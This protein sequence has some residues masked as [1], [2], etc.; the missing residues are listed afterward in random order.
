MAQQ[1]DTAKIANYI[2][3]V[4]N[5]ENKECRPKCMH[6]D[7]PLQ[8]IGDTRKNGKNHRDWFSRRLHK[9]CWKIIHGY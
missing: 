9:K 6:C 4:K 7:K 3:L 2:R 5:R 1:I 8:P